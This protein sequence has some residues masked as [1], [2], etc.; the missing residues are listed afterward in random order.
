MFHYVFVTAGA[1]PCRLQCLAFVVT[2]LFV[3]GEGPSDSPSGNASDE[4]GLFR[5]IFDQPIIVV[6]TV[7]NTNATPVVQAEHFPRLN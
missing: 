2:W 1:C 5:I 3:E 6:N 7:E 4:S